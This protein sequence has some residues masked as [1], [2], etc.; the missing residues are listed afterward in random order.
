MD[1]PARR[2]GRGH[3][4]GLPPARAAGC[5]VCRQG[6]RRGRHPA[7][8][9]GLAGRH[10]E[11]PG[12]PGAAPAAA[13]DAGRRDRARQPQQRRGLSS[14]SV[15]RGESAFPMSTWHPE[16]VKTQPMDAGSFQQPA[17][18]RL[19]WHTTEGSSLPRYQGSAPHFTLD[20]LTGQLWQHAAI[21][22]A[23]LA[24][25]HNRGTVHTNHAHAIQVELIGFTDANFADRVKAY[26]RRVVANWGDAEYTRIAK[27]AR[28]IEA[29]AHVA[30]S[31]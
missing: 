23:A 19:V 21:D 24:L 1:R 20:P 16:A 30:R 18:P 17:P 4:G 6:R 8:V 29:N 28:W 5:A 14:G 12:R 27:L 11:P 15:Q 22:R 31:T 3:G 13:V 26:P 9:P 2:R 7:G 10:R 25:L